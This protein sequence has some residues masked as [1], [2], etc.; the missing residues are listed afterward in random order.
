MWMW[1]AL[2]VLYNRDLLQSS[3]LGLLEFLAMNLQTA[4]TVLYNRDLL[5]ASFLGVGVPGHEDAV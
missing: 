1:S 4:L 2:T 5:Q 3:F